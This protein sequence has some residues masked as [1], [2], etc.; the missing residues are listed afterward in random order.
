[1]TRI[2]PAMMR[3]V[4]DDDAHRSDVMRAPASP[5]AGEAESP[6]SGGAG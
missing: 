1:M 5:L 3:V 2:I 4:T 6:P